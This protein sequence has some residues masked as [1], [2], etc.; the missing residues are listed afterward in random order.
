MKKISF[1]KFHN[2][3]C[4]STK[5]GTLSVLA[6][7]HRNNLRLAMN[8]ENPKIIQ[9]NKII[10]FKKQ[11]VLHLSRFSSSTLVDP[12]VGAFQLIESNILSKNSGLIIALE[13]TGYDGAKIQRE[14]SVLSDWSV[15]KAKLIG[16]NA[17]KLL[18]Y[19][20]PDSKTS[21]YIE[22]LVRRVAEESKENE[23]PLFLE[24][25]T[26][27]IDPLKS[28]LINEDKRSVVIESAMRLAEIGGDVLKLEFP[29][30]IGNNRNQDEWFKACEY[31]SNNITQP[32]VLLSA[33][34]DFA[35]Y[36][37]QV[38]IACQAGASGVAAGRAVWKEAI[39]KKGKEQIR[40]LNDIACNRMRQLTNLVDSFGKPLWEFY[41]TD[42]TCGTTYKQY[43][44]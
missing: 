35:T 3:N 2:L 25:L 21:S 20:N 5:N 8:P 32:W 30:D 39:N 1:G 17:V 40:F 33:S 23:I 27:S 26:Y 19:F 29:F 31:L 13:K 42:N 28:K 18:V 38:Y 41:R 24:I 43:F 44:I 34:V 36:L 9:D 6:I 14:S 15:R 16:A 10:N 4:C 37:N 7:D 22:D 11:V 12:E